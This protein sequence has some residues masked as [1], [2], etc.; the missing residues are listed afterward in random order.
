MIQ[1]KQSLYLLIIFILLSTMF[2]LPLAQFVVNN[3]IYKFIFNGIVPLNNP[4]SS[5]IVSTYP[6]TILIS[7]TALLSFITI[8]LFK[9]RLL[10][11]R[12]CRLNIL[13]LIGF[14]VLLGFY[15]YHF[16][17]KDNAIWQFSIASFFPLISI[18]LYYLAYKGIKKDEDLVKSIDRIR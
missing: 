8:F 13:L 14:N 16:I 15:I 18:I 10:Q 3:E 6:V 7:F 5:L 17:T 4:E 2:F 12:L 1:R 9:N 11:L